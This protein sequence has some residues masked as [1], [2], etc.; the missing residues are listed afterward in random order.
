MRIGSTIA[1]M[2]V[3]VCAG[4]GDRSRSQAAHEIVREGEP[5]A[6]LVA[7]L[8]MPAPSAASLDDLLAQ[9]TK[10]Y[11]K[12]WMVAAPTIRGQLREGERSDHLLV[13]RGGFCYRVLGVAGDGVEDLD[14]LLFDS[15]GVEAQQDP[16][17]DRF[18]A[19]GVQS[20]ICPGS[21]GAFRLQV[22]MYKGS[23]AFIAGVYKTL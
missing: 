6:N 13:L 22:W 7:T 23:G 19:L 2:A 4:C 5:T 12:D 10:K 9:Q 18:P 11:A 8:A 14:L 20:A 3:L 15:N 16:G 21:A 1:A 17:Q